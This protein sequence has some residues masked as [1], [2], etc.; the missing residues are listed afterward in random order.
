MTDGVMDKCNI[1]TATCVI[2]YDSAPTKKLFGKRMFCMAASYPSTQ[3]IMLSW[4]NHASN[5]SAVKSARKHRIF[6]V[7]K[8]FKQ[9]STLCYVFYYFGA[10]TITSNC[11]STFRK[12]F[13]ITSQMSVGFPFRITSV[14]RWQ[15]GRNIAEHAHE[16]LRNWCWGLELVLHPHWRRSVNLCTR[17]RMMF[18]FQRVYLVIIFLCC[19][20]LC[21]VVLSV[22]QSLR[23]VLCDLIFKEREEQKKDD[24]LC[25]FLKAFGQCR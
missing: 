4:I 22:V 18:T 5:S 7:L 12:V 8:L 3:V 15:S 13:N 10:L 23:F 25:T 9:Y 1:R 6:H 14:C 21:S 2:H 24:E 11:H 20:A 16:V 17:W 19:V